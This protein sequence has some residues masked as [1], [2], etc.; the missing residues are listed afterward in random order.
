VIAYERREG[1]EFCGGQLVEG[2]AGG[3]RSWTWN[4]LVLCVLTCFDDLQLK[5]FSFMVKNDDET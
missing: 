1:C 5:T 4:Q 3:S 2:G